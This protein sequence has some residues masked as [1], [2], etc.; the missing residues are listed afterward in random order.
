[1]P[2][3]VRLYLSYIE[4]WCPKMEDAV[5]H[6]IKN[7]S[8]IVHLKIGSREVDMGP[9]PVL[10]KSRERKALPNLNMQGLTKLLEGR[11]KDQVDDRCIVTK[12]AKPDNPRNLY[13]VGS[14]PVAGGWATSLWPTGG[15]LPNSLSTWDIFGV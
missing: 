14:H 2:C 6:Q 7:G 15:H 13:P 3:S 10:E 8:K 9:L 5:T 11:F 1:M 4:K 12:V